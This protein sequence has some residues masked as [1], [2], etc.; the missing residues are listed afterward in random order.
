MHKHISTDPLSYPV[1]GA[2]VPFAGPRVRSVAQNESENE[3]DSHSHWRS[4]EG[5][6]PRAGVAAEAAFLA[7]DG[8]QAPAV[9]DRLR[10][11]LKDAVELGLAVGIA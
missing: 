5:A 4:G 9:A 10:I 8:E 6:G 1:E 3:N 11:A 7:A 2:T